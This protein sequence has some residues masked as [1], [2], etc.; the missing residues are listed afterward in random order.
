[1]NIMIDPG[2]GGKDSGAVGIFPTLK[3]IEKNLTMHYAHA[4][5]EHLSNMSHKVTLTRVFDKFVSLEQRVK[6]SQIFNSDLFLSIHCNSNVGTPASGFEI[7]TSK[8]KTKSDKL[9][10]MIFDRLLNSIIFKLN[11]RIDKSDGDPDKE[12]DFYVLKHTSCPAVLLELGFINNEKDA[13]FLLDPL[14]VED[15]TSLLSL[16]VDEFCQYISLK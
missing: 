11:C 10:D 12:A 13:R 1:M 6:M 3:V 16:A 14:A 5:G 7:W 9:A 8:G 4:L 2:H 15:I